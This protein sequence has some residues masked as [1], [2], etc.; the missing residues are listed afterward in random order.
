[1]E[2]M[3]KTCS[4]KHLED[5]KNK[6]NCLN[7][8]SCY[9]EDTSNIKR[10]RFALLTVQSTESITAEELGQQELSSLYP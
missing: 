2:H 5:E 9:C 6:P 8:I 4:N 1:M 7:A 3:R 10:G